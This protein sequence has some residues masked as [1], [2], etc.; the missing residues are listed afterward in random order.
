MSMS[1]FTKL[2]WIEGEV[3]A[4]W[5]RK[6]LESYNRLSPAID[7][8]TTSAELAA[9]VAEQ[10]R[11]R[12]KD[13]LK[14][15]GFL[16]VMLNV[17]YLAS[18]S[19][20]PLLE[21]SFLTSSSGQIIGQRSKPNRL[22]EEWKFPYRFGT[23][24]GGTSRGSILYM[25]TYVSF[26]ND[27]F[28]RRGGPLDHAAAVLFWL[29]RTE[30]FFQNTPV[31]IAF[32]P[33]QTLKSFLRRLIEEVRK[34]ETQVT[35]VKLM[36]TVMQHIVGAKLDIVLGPGR[37][38]HHSANQADAQYNRS[39]DFELED[40]VIHVTTAPMERLI[41]KCRQNLDDGKRPIIVTLS[42]KTAAA[43]VLAQ[44]EGLE[45]LIEV[46]DFEAFVAYNLFELALARKDYCKIQVEEL[47]RRY[48]ELIE[49]HEPVHGIKLAIKGSNAER[50]E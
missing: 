35:G 17:T 16:A 46:I 31:D 2:S 34:R 7:A 37:L 45:D 42:S 33:K 8:A 39:G 26:L 11:A 4:D 28:A 32:L 50:Q 36:G 48:N 38:T 23:E 3:D 44:N 40:S 27:V 47:I 13:P 24:S 6:L 43:E 41:G 5:L 9:F 10:R 12:P 18:R 14:I 20:Y 21:A 15:A 25:R 22:L 49:K 19:E 29:E 30:A 1:D